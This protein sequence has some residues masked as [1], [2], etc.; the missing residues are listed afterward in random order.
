[1][2]LSK[3]EAL[4]AERDPLEVINDIYKE[5]QEGVKMAPEHIDL[6][7]WY[8]MYP[9]ANSKDEDAA[10]F[11]KRIKLVDSSMTQ[12][13]LGVMADITERF[14]QNYADFTVRQNV[15]FHYIQIKDLPEIF[16][17][18][19]SVG[20]TSKLA[21][22]D[23]PRPIVTCPV[24]GLEKDYI[25][26]VVP[27][28]KELDKYFDRH[29]AEFSNL[30]RKYKVGISGC[31]CHCM[32]HEIQDVG[33]TAFKRGSG[34][35]FDLSIG[36]GLGKSKQIASRAKRYVRPEQIKDVCIK[37]A[38]IFREHGNRENRGK[39]RVRH[40]LNDWGMEK[41]VQELESRLGYKLKDGA[42][43]PKLTPFEKREHFGVHESIK[44]G[45]SYIGCATDRGRV[46]GGMKKLYA[47]VKKYDAEGVRL[48]TTQ[49][50]IVYGV[51][52][53][54]AQSMA[55]ELTEAGFST[56]PSRFEARTQSCTGLNF[57]KFAIS[58][59]KD[60]SS[61]LIKHLEKKF[62][63]FKDDIIISV[64]GCPNGCSHPQISHIGLQG[65]K[66]KNAAGE[67]VQG[68]ELSLGGTLHGESNSSFAQKA[69]LKLAAE[70]VTGFV[71][72]LVAEFLATR[73]NY[74]DFLEFSRE[75]NTPENMERIKKG[76]LSATDVAKSESSDNISEHFD[77]DSMKSKLE[78]NTKKAQEAKEA[79]EAEAKAK[80]EEARKRAQEAQEERAKSQTIVKKATELDINQEVDAEVKH[81]LKR[82][83]ARYEEEVLELRAKV[84]ELVMENDKLKKI[85]ALLKEEDEL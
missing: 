14:A 26:D 31:K 82:V 52:N 71:E 44:D 58:E 61:T 65:C 5:A 42:D 56:N 49:N 20:L 30:P 69:G 37:I 10:Y 16:E 77:Y 76:E 51:K 45:Y 85:I 12:E 34:T 15:Q 72:N 19:K 73:Q 38:E 18:L 83:K 1:M 62:P 67:R 43:E 25:Y 17:L 53:S 68:F 6:L 59:T 33:L 29:S 55:I 78:E 79:A 39:A 48:T 23:G 74:K 13:Q 84:G 46:N 64:S 41:F 57:C 9:H 75:I 63:D 60:F 80:R 27:F 66:A 11:M 2:A 8:G 4:K 81:Q 54:V 40:L 28:V 22:G 21:S 32:G 24:S 3:V 47:L 7:K 50:F 70:E 35:F 36:G